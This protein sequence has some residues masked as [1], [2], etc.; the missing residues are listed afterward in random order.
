MK[1]KK[2]RA[3]YFD[4]DTNALEFYYQKD[5][6]NNAYKDIQRFLEKKN[7]KHEQGSVYHSVIPMEFNNVLMIIRELQHK[8][9]WFSKSVNS[10]D[11]AVITKRTN[12]TDIFEHP[13]TRYNVKEIEAYI[14]RRLE[15]GDSLKRIETQFKV[16]HKCDVKLVKR[17]NMAKKVLMKNKLIDLENSR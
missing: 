1:G 4:L 5:N 2:F 7:F 15:K 13:S 6:W 17:F 3:I 11:V 10:F 12:V 8:Y 16:R 9:K 14:M